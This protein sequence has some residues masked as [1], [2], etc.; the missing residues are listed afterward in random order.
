MPFVSG[1]PISNIS[2][3]RGN[4]RRTTPVLHRS[5]ITN[6]DKL[7]TVG[8]LTLADVV[9][10]GSLV[11]N[12]NYKVAAAAGNRHGPAIPS[13]VANLTLA[14]DA[15]STHVMDVLIPTVTNAEWYDVFLSTDAAPKWVGR[16][17]AAQLAAGGFRITA[18]GT[19]ASGGAAAAGH[20]YVEVVGTGVATTATPFTF[21]NSWTPQ[22]ITPVSGA[23]YTIA[24]LMYEI[25]YTDLRVDP[26]TSGVAIRAYVFQ[27]NSI[28]GNYEQLSS[29]SDSVISQSTASG[30][31]IQRFITINGADSIVVCFSDAAGT[32]GG[33][34]SG[35][36]ATV[37]AWLSFA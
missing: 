17:T 21:N 3:N 14:A 34:F 6:V 13:A 10:G 7:A 35:Q 18:V 5:A 8:S 2:E 25:S 22:L 26:A 36:G 30:L 1:G 16:V 37:S 29:S 12:T 4:T 23:G 27:L 11:F 24:V 9:T 15:A 32:S 28:S 19:Y 20:I 31:L 33:A